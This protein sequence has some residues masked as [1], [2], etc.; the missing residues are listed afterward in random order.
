MID[1]INYG[2]RPLDERKKRLLWAML[3]TFVF[4]MLANGYSYFNFYPIHDAVDFTIGGPWLYW[5]TQLGRFL[6]P[7]YLRFRSPFSMPWIT[8][9]LS[10]GYLGLCVY[11]VA[12]LLGLNSRLGI[13]LTAGFLSANIFM[14]EI[15][16]AQQYFSDVFLLSTLL[17]CLGIYSV[18][19]GRGVKPFAA[20]VGCLFLSFGVYQASITFAACLCMLAALRQIVEEQKLSK[21]VLAK[22]GLCVAA[23]GAAGVLYLLASGLVLNAMG[24]EPSEVNWSIYSANQRKLPELLASLKQN[25]AGFVKVMFIGRG[26]VGILFGLFTCLMAA[27]GLALAVRRLWKRK[28]ALLCVVALLALF[29]MVSRLINVFTKM[30]GAFRTMFAMFLILPALVGMIFWSLPQKQR[31]RVWVIAATV[32]LSAT[33][34]VGNIRY[35]NGAFTVQR[36]LNERAVYHTGRVLQDLD[37]HDKEKKLALLGRFYLYDAERMLMERYV[38]INGFFYD[39]G[40]DGPYEFVHYAWLLGV[41]LNWEPEYADEVRDLPEVVDMPA[42]PNDGYILETDDYVVVRLGRKPAKEENTGSNEK[43]QLKKLTATEAE[44]PQD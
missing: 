14:L 36:I 28:L 7:I 11:A 31:T 16:T 21:A 3:A 39:S 6:T 30:D 18:W 35:T 42:Y 33:V 37:G 12:D 26:Y 23:V 32:L 41:D 27:L 17:A 29:P 13:T 2:M 19:K 9:L 10:M 15:N 38:K 1:K 25:Y 40:A 20:G 34:I 5:Q 44:A 8:G 4:S 43:T 22:V 24:R